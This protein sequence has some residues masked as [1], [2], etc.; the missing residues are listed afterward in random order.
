MDD[1]ATV[2]SFASLETEPFTGLFGFAQLLL[3]AVV[4]D[5]RRCRRAVGIYN[6]QTQKRRNEKKRQNEEKELKNRR[7][8]PTPSAALR[9]KST[10]AKSVKVVSMNQC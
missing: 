9:V 10:S 6:G 4:I 1:V 5:N 8:R 3:E 2:V 7:L